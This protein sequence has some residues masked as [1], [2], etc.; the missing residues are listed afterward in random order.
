MGS[1]GIKNTYPYID[2]RSTETDHKS[3]YSVRYRESNEY[4]LRLISAS[5]TIAYHINIS[6]VS[7]GLVYA[8]IQT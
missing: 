2:V 6:T 3:D 1:T 4:S 8:Q 5:M 7:L